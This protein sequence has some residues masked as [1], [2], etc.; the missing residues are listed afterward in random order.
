MEQQ[1]DDGTAASSKGRSVLVTVMNEKEGWEPF[2]DSQC[3][4]LSSLSFATE[5]ANWVLHVLTRS[6]ETVLRTETIH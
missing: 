6:S 4:L 1:K 5:V 3:F 2:S